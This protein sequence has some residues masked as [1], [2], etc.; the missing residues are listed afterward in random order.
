MSD[1]LCEIDISDID[2]LDDRYNISLAEPEITALARSIRENGLACLPVVRPLDNKYIIVSGFNR[3]RA[4]VCNEVNRAAVLKTEPD[5]SDALCLQRSISAIAFK[6]E[7]TQAELVRSVRLL[8]THYSTKEICD[9]SMGLFNLKLNP[10]YVEQLFC[11]AQLGDSVMSMIQSG[12]IC[13]KA[14]QQLTGF[15]KDDIAA[16]L[17]VFKCVRAS[18]NIQMEILTWLKEIAARDKTPMQAVSKQLELDRILSDDRLD[19]ALKLRQLRNRL[20]DHRF[21]ELSRARNHVKEKIAALKLGQG[22]RFIP[23]ENFERQGYN[24]SFTIKNP[25]EFN[26]IVSSLESL[27]RNGAIK[28]ILSP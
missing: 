8:K 12:S 2:L 11:V 26:A 27:C 23:P 17:R 19:N 24:I 22:I 14:A 1:T 4:L 5:I 7:L 18:K 16:C 9:R 10:A 25:D 6:R 3:I 13:I 28:E 21:P 20:F 15:G